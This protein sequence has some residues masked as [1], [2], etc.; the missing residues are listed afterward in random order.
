MIPSS[1]SMLLDE[2]LTAERSHANIASLQ[3]DA[4]REEMIQDAMKAEKA[5]AEVRGEDPAAVA[6]PDAVTIKETKHEIPIDEDAAR[7]GF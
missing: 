7:L 3:N 1:A 2:L 4:A 5:T 6:R